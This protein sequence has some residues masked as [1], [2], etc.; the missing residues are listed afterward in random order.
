MNFTKCGMVLAA[1]M[2]SGL[3]LTPAIAQNGGP[4]GAGDIALGL[5]R[6]DESLTMEHI[7][8]GALVGN[9]TGT[10]WIQ[11]VEF[12]NLD[13]KSH[14]G[15]GNLLGLNWGGSS[16][17]VLWSM[18]TDGSDTASQLYAFDGSEVTQTPISGLSVSPDNQHVAV[19]GYGS[20]AL[21]LLDYV[22]GDG[23]GNGST[24]L[25]YEETFFA[26]VNMTQGTCWL[27][28]DTVIGFVAGLVAGDF[29]IV[30]FDINSHVQTT[31]ISFSTLTSGSNFMDVDY[32]PLVSPYVYATHSGYDGAG[33]NTLIVIDPTDWSVVNEVDLTGSADTLRENSLG[34][35]ND[36][37]A[38]YF[39]M[40]GGDDL[41]PGPWIDVI[42]VSSPGSIADDSSV[43][44]YRSTVDSS[45][46]GIDVALT[47]DDIISDC[48]T[49]DVANLVA[50]ESATF[51]ITGGTPD[52]KA[53]TVYGF[54]PGNTPVNNVAGYCVNFD[55]KGVSQ[56]K[57]LGGLNKKF[58]GSGNI[59][60]NL[61]IPSNSAGT[62]VYFQSA[63]NGTCPEECK[64]NLV[65]E[66]I[67]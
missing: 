4:S 51:T 10:G 34:F 3:G 35:W 26:G 31:E 40:Y 16:G 17:G 41:D 54:Q 30:T 64:S 36:A 46:N 28:N 2:S 20:G 5:S 62:N 50:G 49:L 22:A 19:V 43:D 32:N 38:L 14:N 53:V 8:D 1:S 7:R 15:S 18:S 29:D 60:F 13:G 12:D 57:V 9:W 61:P 37:P 33:H 27:D 44:F 11:S 47:G 48:I 45:F 63:M 66:I 25:K 55:I 23:S 6:S 24:T 56:S 39:S 67:Q 58:N 42:D 21:I 59:Q 65:Q 52:V